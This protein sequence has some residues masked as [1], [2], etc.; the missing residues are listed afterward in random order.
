MP[1]GSSTD[2]GEEE[3]IQVQHWTAVFSLKDD[4]KCF[5]GGPWM[6]AEAE[7]LNV[8]MQSHDPGAL[9]D[10]TET[11]RAWADG[12]FDSHFS[13][14]PQDGISDRMSVSTDLEP[15]TPPP[16]REPLAVAPEL[17]ATDDGDD[18][19]LTLELNET[20]ST[21]KLMGTE[22]LTTTM[23]T[24]HRSADGD[25][26]KAIDASAV[27]TSMT[28]IVSE[29]LIQF[30]N[31]LPEP[32]LPTSLRAFALKAAA[33][34]DEAK[35]LSIPPQLTNASSGVFHELIDLG[36]QVLTAFDDLVSSPT[37][38][39]LLPLSPSTEGVSR[40]TMPLAQ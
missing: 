26:V 40:R 28:A 19:A 25:E 38:E 1:E 39:E 34:R 18:S 14:P 37:A 6:L 4:A 31:S 23:A 36:S 10:Y 21:P 30:I 17:E 33:K 35:L 13:R 12:Y 7:R 9:A 15:G 11:L 3:E 32:P 5:A 27:V 20:E 29:V 16:G 2:W 8:M 22:G 24:P